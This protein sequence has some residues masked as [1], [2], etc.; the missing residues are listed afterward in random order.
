MRAMQGRRRGVEA[1]TPVGAYTSWGYASFT[2]SVTPPDI[3]SL[4]LSTGA[5]GVAV[6]GNARLQNLVAASNGNHYCAG[7][8]PA[9]AAGPYAVR[10]GNGGGSQSTDRGYG[11][12]YSAADGYVA[13]MA[14]CFSSGSG[15]LFTAIGGVVTQ[16]ATGSTATSGSGSDVLE[17]RYAV[18]GSDIIYTLYKSTGG[19]A[20]TATNLTWTDTN[21]AIAGIPGRYPIAH[22]RPVRNAGTTYYP[23]GIDLFQS[24]ML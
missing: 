4:A 5:P 15:R 10:V 23:P 20:F 11:P 12:G 18:S 8:G 6:D 3:A 7:R 14:A 22:L 19:G 13:V 17:M 21:A 1:K 24:E 9:M 2:P 16:R